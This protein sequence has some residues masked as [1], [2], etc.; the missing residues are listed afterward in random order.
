MD[1]RQRSQAG[2][3]I[4][5]AAISLTVLAVAL[6]TVWGTLVYSSRSN[7]AAEQKKQ[8]LNAAR[9]KLEEL[10]ASTFDTLIT[11]YGPGAANSFAVPTLGEG[12]SQGSITFYVDETA[13]S[14]GTDLG[15][16]R[17]LNADG[18]TVDTDVSSDYALVAV[19][20]T[21]SWTGALGAQEVHVGSLLG[22]GE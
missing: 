13:V 3:T 10:R 4:L 21:V 6:I 18:D 17:D 11:D 16:P 9:A 12:N 19:R 14:G 7:V 2:V 5:E 20:V 1:V 15:L 8:A 22:D